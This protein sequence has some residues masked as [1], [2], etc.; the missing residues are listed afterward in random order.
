MAS[1]ESCTTPLSEFPISFTALIGLKS[2]SDKAS[3]VPIPTVFTHL[4]TV[5]LSIFPTPFTRFH[6]T[7]LAFAQRCCVLFQNL[8]HPESHAVAVVFTSTVLPYFR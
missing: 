2:A 1:A 7:V 3:D 6:H 5:L 4:T 8:R